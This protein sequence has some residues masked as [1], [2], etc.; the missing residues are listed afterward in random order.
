VLR[1]VAV[2]LGGFG[3]FLLLMMIVMLGVFVPIGS[4]IDP[5]LESVMLIPFALALAIAL[6]LARAA[7]AFPNHLPALDRLRSE[8][9]QR[10]TIVVIWLLTASGMLLLL[11]NTIRIAAG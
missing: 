6:P 5:Q 4:L 11:T 10:F 9:A 2:V 8:P 1:P 3:L 7:M